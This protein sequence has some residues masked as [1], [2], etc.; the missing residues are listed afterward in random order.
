MQRFSKLALRLPKL[1]MRFASTMPTNNTEPLE[2]QVVATSL[3]NK[4]PGDSMAAK[5]SSFT[6]GTSVLALLI[7]KEIYIVDAEFFELLCLFGAYYVWYSNGKEGAIQYFANKQ[8]VSLLIANQVC[9][10]KCAFGSQTSRSRTYRSHWKDERYC[11]SHR[12][13]VWFIKGNGRDGS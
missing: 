10:G 8:K 11:Q 7:S 5:A 6:I 9:I 12:A 1:P 13:I 4:F 3:L 2:H